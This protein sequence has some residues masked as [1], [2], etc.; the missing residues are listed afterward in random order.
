MDFFVWN[1]KFVDFLGA[2]FPWKDKEKDSP[3]NPLKNLKGAFGPKSTQEMI[4]E[5]L[6]SG[7]DYRSTGNYYTLNSE[8]NCTV[9]VTIM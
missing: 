6:K 8:H 1:K 4:S 2:T 5:N 7:K 3:Q 9:T